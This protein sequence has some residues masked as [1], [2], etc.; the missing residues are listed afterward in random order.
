MAYFQFHNLRSKI[1]HYSLN[2]RGNP[3]LAANFN[4]RKVLVAPLD[5]GLGHATRDISIIRA[6]V[7]NGYEVI[8]AAE[9][10][11]ASLLQTEFP[12]LQLLPLGGYHIRYS[13]TQ[14]GFLFT[15]LLQ[16]PRVYNVIKTENHWLEKIVTEQHIDL[17]IT[18]NRFGLHSK[19]IPC[20][21]ITHQLT[22][23]A[24][25]TWL[26][27]LMQ[28]VNYSYINQFSCCWVPDVAGAENAAGILS[29]P[30]KMPKIQVNYIGL[31]SRFQMQPESNQYDYCILLSGPEPQRTLL[32]EKI[33]AGVA[34]ING[35]ILLVRGKPG[36]TE[37]L[38]VPENVEVQNHLPTAA[39]QKALLQ[40]D[41]I[42][43][44]GGYTSVMELLSLKKKMLVIPTPGQTEQE[45]LAKKLYESHICLS[46]TQTKL[47]C[48][49]HFAMSK[50]FDYHLP[51]FELFSEKGITDLL[52]RSV[53]NKH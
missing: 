10:A 51:A 36:S 29:H 49:E 40:S 21:F 7:A 6:L 27:K 13:K 42:V 53:V 31:L 5:W 38:K 32:E 25:F 17:V 16:I 8:I 14:L 9:G 46:V 28:L 44:R 11:Q 43:C 26:E 30:R 45:Y 2:S 50:K 48:V 3:A 41:I 37:V 1:L 24:P 22:V 15:I 23:K 47:N 19:K 18:D 4:I 39:L 20:I 12:S 52:K 33:L 35:K 34:T